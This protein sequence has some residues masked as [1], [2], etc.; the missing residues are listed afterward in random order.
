MHAMTTTTPMPTTIGLTGSFCDLDP[1]TGE[2]IAE[3]AITQPEEITA[4]VAKAQEAW[5]AWAA[6]PLEERLELLM[7]GCRRLYGMKDQMAPMIVRE[8]GKPLAEAE[9][10][11]ELWWLGIEATFDSYRE[12]F[13]EEV[14]TYKRHR[15]RRLRDPQGVVAA[16]SP[17]NFPMRMPINIVLPALAAGNAVVL[18]PTEHAPLVG[19]MIVEA[20]AG[21]LPDGVIGL[22]QGGGASGAALVAADVN[23]VGF[24]GSKATGQA[25]MRSA[26]DGLKRLV[27]ELGGKDPLFVFADADLD[28]AA[29]CAVTHSLRNT[30][31]VCCSVER[32]F[33]AESVKADF[34]AKVLELAKGW[35]H[36]NGFDEGVR[37]GPM[38][39]ADQR[40]K[41]HA[42]VEDA[43]AAGARL[44]MGGELPSGPGSFYPATVVADA[45][46]DC[47]LTEEET[48]GPVVAIYGFDGTADEA[49]RLA[50]LSEYGLAANIYAGDE[51]FAGALARRLRFGQIGINRYISS[52]PGSPWVGA[53][54]SGFGFLG[55]IEGHRQ[56]TIPKSVTDSNPDA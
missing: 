21:A 54:Q 17:W 9:V 51:A 31:Q 56:F 15:T 46:L 41:C 36:G 30:G 10:E 38:V 2:T 7:G 55:G 32:V 12:A 50:H 49:V 18:K 3:V 1:A 52:A 13:A 35:T 43:V 28:A 40:A 44:L 34:E 20:F 4:L 27:L 33:V 26:A 39:S 24:V 19:A 48:F 25:I 6:L 14:V 16:V 5:P 45:P 8:M 29:K 22:V 42:Q 23:M 53:R 11:V 47:S 37:M